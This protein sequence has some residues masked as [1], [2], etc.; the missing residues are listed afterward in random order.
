MWTT[1]PEGAPSSE[2][3]G[4]SLDLQRH[5]KSLIIVNPQVRPRAIYQIHDID[6]EIDAVALY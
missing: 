6:F 5:Q 1:G 2:S 4:R 3:C